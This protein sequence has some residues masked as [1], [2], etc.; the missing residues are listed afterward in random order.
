M[1]SDF[2]SESREF[3]QAISLDK[4]TLNSELKQLKWESTFRPR[5]QTIPSHITHQLTCKFPSQRSICVILDSGNMLICMLV[6]RLWP[7]SLPHRSNS[8]VILSWNNCLIQT[9][10]QITWGISHLCW[11]YFQNPSDFSSY[12]VHRLTPTHKNI[13]LPFTSLA[14]IRLK[15]HTEASGLHTAAHFT[16]REAENLPHP[17]RPC[18]TYGILVLVRVDA[19]VHD[20]SEQVVH[21]AGQ[22]LSVQHAVQRTHKHRLAGVQAL[23]GAAHV[24]TVRDHPGDHLHL[25]Q[26][27]PTGVTS[28]A[29]AAQ[30]TQEGSIIQTVMIKNNQLV[31]KSK[32][33]FWN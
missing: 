2:I 19:R 7:H 29:G 13:T 26:E 27:G 31:Y 11:K 22:R 30:K 3:I 9:K 23:G 32:R 18:L 21:D 6:P 28:E 20:A 14:V 24:V 17:R 15:T 12:P 5:D 33:S 1:N 4:L 8:K 25:E 16:S 10:I